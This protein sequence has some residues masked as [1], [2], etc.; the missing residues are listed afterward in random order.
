MSEPSVLEIQLELDTD[1]VELDLQ[2]DTD[3]TELTFAMDNVIPVGGVEDYEK[4]KNKPQIN[5]V[6]LIGNKT[7][8]EL[9]IETEETE[10]IEWSVLKEIWEHAFTN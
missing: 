7:T 8:E 9:K 1:D 4:L 10:E 5:G 3:D 2:L 6:T